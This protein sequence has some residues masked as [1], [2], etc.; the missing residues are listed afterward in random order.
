VVVHHRSDKSDKDYRGSTDIRAVVDSA[1]SV[2]RDDQTGAG[3]ALGMLMLKP[4]KA[5]VRPGML[6]RIEYRD[7]KFL[8][9]DAPPESPIDILVD[10]IAVFPGMTQKELIERGKTQGFGR[11]KVVSLA[12][13]AVLGRQL[14]VRR[15]GKGGTVRY[16]LPGP[17]LLDSE[18]PGN[19]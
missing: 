17:V 12:Q 7:G 8:S 2:Q 15:K 14:E 4:F 13:Q 3:D 18:A 6:T 10:L 5:R 11:D 19:A 16:Y 9:R 1:S